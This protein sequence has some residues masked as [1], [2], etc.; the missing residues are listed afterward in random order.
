MNWKLDRHRTARLSVFAVLSLAV[1]APAQQQTS[2]P[3]AN[4]AAN[5]K[6]LRHYTFKQRMEIYHKGE[7]KNA[8]IDEVHYNLSGERVSIPLEE[9]K[10][11]P[12]PRRRGPGS[13]L[14]AKRIEQE[15]DNM[16]E[17][18][19]RLMALTSRYL[20]PDPA[21]LE[22]AV[23][24]A[25]VTTG[26]ADEVRVVMRDYAKPGDRMTMSFDST[27]RRPAKAE[28][29]TSLDDVPVSIILSFDQI[30]EGPAYPGKTVIR[31]D[32]KQLEL[33]V[34]TYDYRL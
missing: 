19:E 6:Q 13:R 4:V 31:S 27:T 12:E 17:Y 22:R 16:K 25:Q 3:L 15:Q 18:I 7:L 8:R 26:G 14:I 28:V 32:V 34:F 2:A 23:A 9:S 30:H 10:A 20:T 5:A 29:N 21:R 24:N 11:Q 1:G 33:R